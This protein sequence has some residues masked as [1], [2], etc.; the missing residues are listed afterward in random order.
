M[1]TSFP[2]VQ[3]GPPSLQTS[4]EEQNLRD[5]D[6]H[7]TF[8]KETAR[9][10]SNKRVPWPRTETA[11]EEDKQI[12]AVTPPPPLSLL[13]RATFRETDRGHLRRVR[14]GIHHLFSLLHFLVRTPHRPVRQAAK[15]T[16]N[17]PLRASTRGFGPQ[18][19][20]K[21]NHPVPDSGHEIPL[22]LFCLSRNMFSVP[23]F[24]LFI[25]PLSLSFSIPPVSPVSTH[26]NR[27]QVSSGE[28]SATT[29]SKLQLQP[30][31][32]CCCRRR[33]RRRRRRPP[34]LKLRRTPLRSRWPG[35]QTSNPSSLT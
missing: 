19:W 15:S 1:S 31:A 24:S 23:S 7:Q 25:L 33:R 29:P 8:Q 17:R 6:H 30:S 21:N 11:S 16:I 13:D 22:N 32:S 4:F 20:L 18:H 3:R 26:Q 35:R 9:S 14:S 34:G 28:L 12:V 10:P 2:L 5:S 27:I